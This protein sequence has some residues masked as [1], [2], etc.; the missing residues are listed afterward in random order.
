MGVRSGMPA[1]VADA[2]DPNRSGHEQ[3]FL[4]PTPAAQKRRRRA[5]V[6]IALVVFAVELAVEFLLSVLNGPEWMK[7]AA[8][9]ILP[10]GGLIGA[11]GVNLTT[12]PNEGAD[13]YP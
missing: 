4:R 5:I 8:I 13:G 1:D 12:D 2:I 10:I 7:Q 11:S 9:L 6:R 3:M